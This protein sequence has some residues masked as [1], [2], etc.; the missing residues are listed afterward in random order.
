MLNEADQHQEIRDAVRHLCSEFPDE[1]FRKVDEQRAYPEKFV[2]ALMEAGWLAAMIPEE[3]GGTGLG[4]TAAT[5]DHGGDQPL[6]RQLR[7]RAW[8]DVQHGHAAAQRQQGAERAST[9]LAS[10]LASCAS[11]RW[12]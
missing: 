10:P 4:L 7:R 6:R 3:Y 12:R 5:R 11:S 9:C 1:Y 2:D 8:P